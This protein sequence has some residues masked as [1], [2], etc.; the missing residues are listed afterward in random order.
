MV[1]FSK[2][3]ESVEKTSVFFYTLFSIFRLDDL[4]YLNSKTYKSNL[5][6]YTENTLTSSQTKLPSLLLL[7]DQDY[8]QAYFHLIFV[9]F[10][11]W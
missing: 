5:L 11:D 8:R 7:R 9:H 4:N 2:K 6:L 10:A 3:E 1:L